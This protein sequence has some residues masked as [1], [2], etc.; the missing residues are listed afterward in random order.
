MIKYFFTIFLS[1]LFFNQTLAKD[2]SI[3][4]NIDLEFVCD[5][6]KKIIKNSEYNYQTFL[7]KDLNEKGLDS[8]KILSKKP[9][10]LFIKGLSSFL[11]VSSKLNVKVVNKDVVLFKS[12][13][14][15]K[16][17]SESGIITIKTGE[18][19]HEI[20]KNMKSENS[21]KYIFIYS[22]NKDDKKV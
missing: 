1:L 7:A 2:V 15:E 22:C 14:Q 16:N 17:Y 9:E 5:L 21:E 19:I 20:T 12:I 6:E 11:S 4:E 10:T 8:F 18:L 3:N 13:D